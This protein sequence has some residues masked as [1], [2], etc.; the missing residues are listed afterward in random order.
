MS[1]TTTRTTLAVSVA[2]TDMMAFKQFARMQ[3]LQV[4]DRAITA[5]EIEALMCHCLVKPVVP[6]AEAGFEL[7]QAAQCD[8]RTVRDIELK[9]A[10]DVFDVDAL[11]EQA[12]LVFASAQGNVAPHAMTVSQALYELTVAN[13]AASS[14]CGLECR[15]AS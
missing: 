11:Q 1:K 2:I 15:L 8:V 6:P 4:P 3:G 10:V 12:A 5:N 14:A 13:S 9:L 7:T